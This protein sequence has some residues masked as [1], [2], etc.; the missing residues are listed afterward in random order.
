[1]GIHIVGC[2]YI[3]LRCVLKH[4][5]RISR[6]ASCRPDVTYLG[7]DASGGVR[8]NQWLSREGKCEKDLEQLVNALVS[9]TNQVVF[10]VRRGPCLL[11]VAQSRSVF[12]TCSQTNAALESRASKERAGH[13]F[14][15][16]LD[17]L[18]HLNSVTSLSTLILKL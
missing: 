17:L 13:P 1:M 12:S 8:A 18:F 11:S 9:F 6:E 5:Q 15:H 10:Q 7:S 14:L 16:R 4:G 2:C 3:H